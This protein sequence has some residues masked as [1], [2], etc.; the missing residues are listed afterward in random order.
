M[1]F[2]T[3]LLGTIPNAR[4]LIRR[5]MVVEKHIEVLPGVIKGGI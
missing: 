5:A 1:L 2:T 4:F 3:K